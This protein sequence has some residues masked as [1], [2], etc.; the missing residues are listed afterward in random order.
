MRD[1]RKE[2]LDVQQIKTK[3]I[4]KIAQMKFG[5]K[6]YYGKLKQ[7]SHDKYEVAFNNG[8]IETFTE[9]EVYS[10]RF[11]LTA[12]DKKNYSKVLASLQY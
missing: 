8:K 3:E 2:G 1:L 10:R 4:P 7:V 9:D 6:F 12:A 5:K 11:P